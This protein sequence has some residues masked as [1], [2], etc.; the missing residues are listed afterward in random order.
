MLMRGPAARRLLGRGRPHTQ[1]SQRRMPRTGA[2]PNGGRG[3]AA[4]VMTSAAS[5]LDARGGDRVT[6]PPIPSAATTWPVWSRIGAPMQR[7]PSSYSSLST[8]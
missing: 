1:R 3:R 4:A 2:R 6:G 5:S 8:A 7:R